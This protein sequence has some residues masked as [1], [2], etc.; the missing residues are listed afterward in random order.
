MPKP[1]KCHAPYVSNY[2]PLLTSIILYSYTRNTQAHQKVLHM[3]TPANECTCLWRNVFGHLISQRNSAIALCVYI[4]V[5]VKTGRQQQQR[6]SDIILIAICS[7]PSCQ[8]KHH[9]SPQ[10]HDSFGA[11]PLV[12]KQLFQIE[13]FLQ[14]FLMDQ[15]LITSLQGMGVA[16]ERNLYCHALEAFR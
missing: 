15:Q 1:H 8:N 16:N 9:I 11:N 13:W 10:S 5:L 4:G 12:W 2:S 6:M 7:K 3:T 14:F